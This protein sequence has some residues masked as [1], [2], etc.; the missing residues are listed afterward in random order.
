MKCSTHNVD[1]IIQVIEE[2]TNLSNI[3]LPTRKRQ[4]VDARRI[5]YF[6]LR[7]IYRLSYQEIGDKCGG[8]NHATILHSIKDIEFMCKSDSNFKENFD[9]CKSRL[10]G[11]KTEKELLLEKIAILEKE[12]L[13]IKQQRNEI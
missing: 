4:Y 9:N 7:K 8:K 12:L 10:W 6:L 1:S 2:E 3:L 5:L 11:V 13:T